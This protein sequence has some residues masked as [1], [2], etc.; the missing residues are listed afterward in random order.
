MS[1]SD[2]HNE[3][4][5][6]IS[7]VFTDPVM[8]KKMVDKRMRKMDVAMKEVSKLFPVKLE[9][10]ADADVT[11]VGW[12]S[13]YNLLM[14]LQ[15]RLAEEGTKAN[16]LMIKVI[17]PFLSDEVSAILTKCKRPIIIESNYTSQMARLI[18]M[19]TGFTIKDKILKYDGEPFPAGTRVQRSEKDSLKRKVARRSANRVV[20]VGAGV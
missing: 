6:V 4:G 18:R 14:A 20:R 11:L 5:E 3:R 13:T 2:E 12:G 7:D 9:G 1:A 10:P 19:E 16:I 8:R 17:A 15:R